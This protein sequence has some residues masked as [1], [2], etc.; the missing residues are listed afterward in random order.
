MTRQLTLEQRVTRLEKLLKNEADDTFYYSE[1]SEEMFKKF[2]ADNVFNPEGARYSDFRINTDGGVFIL[3][4]PADL[5]D[6]LNLKAPIVSRIVDNVKRRGYD[7]L[8]F[9]DGSPNGHDIFINVSKSA[10]YDD[11]DLDAINRHR[12]AY[13]RSSNGGYYTRYNRW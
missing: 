12:S 6:S 3:E 5:L 11:P 13:S 2:L 9:R 7:V 8:L 10:S 1:I 4:G